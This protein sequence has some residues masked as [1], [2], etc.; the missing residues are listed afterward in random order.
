MPDIRLMD[1]EKPVVTE[2]RNMLSQTVRVVLV[3][4]LMGVALAGNAVAGPF[5]D[6]VSAFERG[7]YVEA[8][9]FFREAAERGD[10]WAQSMLGSMYNEGR[11]VSPDYAEALKWF[12]RAADQGD[13]NAQNDLGLIYLYGQ[14]VPQNYAEAEKWFREAADQGD[15]SAQ[16]SLSFIYHYGKGVPQ[17]YVKG[18]K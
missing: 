17:D 16:T 4:L 3:A 7:G 13:A 11:G 2:S 15:A 18:V 5:E 8:A 1:A 14:G 6:G 9:K 12:R 10:A